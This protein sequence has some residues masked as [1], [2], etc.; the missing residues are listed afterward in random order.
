MTT[1]PPH[2][3]AQKMPLEELIVA[4]ASDERFSPQYLLNLLM[5]VGTLLSTI[6]D[7]RS[8]L[9]R[10]QTR[11][12]G[13]LLAN[14][15]QTQTD[16]ANALEIHKVSVGIYISELEELGLVERRQH[17]TDRRAKCIFLT[18]R[19]HASKHIGVETY[20]AIHHIATEGI[21]QKAY[22]GM[23]DCIALMRENLNTRDRQE[24]DTSEAAK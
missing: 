9:T 23:L 7:R 16:L 14:D 18:P 8:P 21:D 20:A 13:V 19:L 3:S 24:R 10:Q 6:Y 11:L 22:L 1:T 5:N 2:T 15:G 4:D 12:I 17:P